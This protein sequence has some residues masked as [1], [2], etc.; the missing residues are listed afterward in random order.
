VGVAFSP[1]GKLV[2]TASFDTTVKIW[3]ASTGELLHNL[4]GHKAAVWNVVFTPDCKRLISIGFDNL[5]KVW[6][7]KAL[8]AGDSTA[9][10]LTFSGHALGP[11]IALSPDG[12]YLA[13]PT[14]NGTVRVYVLPIEELISL[15]QDRLTRTWTSEECQRFLDLDQCPAMP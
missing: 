9:E 12:N 5:V 2:A 15:A 14:A 7:L 4:E 8:A 3:D 6:D 1:D 11:D 13:V 10:V